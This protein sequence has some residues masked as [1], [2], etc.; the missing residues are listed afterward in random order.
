MFGHHPFVWTPLRAESIITFKTEGDGE[1][2]RSMPNS[3]T[4]NW[5][6]DT[7]ADN[8]WVDD[9]CEASF[10]LAKMD[11]DT[12][13]IIYPRESN[14]NTGEWWKTVNNEGGADSMVVSGHWAGEPY[15]D[16]YTRVMK[17][18]GNWSGG[19]DGFEANYQGEVS[20]E[21]IPTLTT[22]A[23]PALG[24][25]K[26]AWIASLDEIPTE[27][28]EPE[29]EPCAYSNWSEWG[30]CTQVMST[31]DGSED[32]KRTRTRTK[33]SGGA[34]CND[35]LEEEEMC[36]S[37]Q[38]CEW[39]DWSAWSEWTECDWNNAD[40][41]LTQTRTRQK[42]LISP[43]SGGQAED[44]CPEGCQ[45][46]DCTSWSGVPI[47]ETQSR[48]CPESANDCPYGTKS[49]T[50]VST[51]SDGTRVTKY[52]CISCSQEL[53]DDPNAVNTSGCPTCKSGYAQSPSN[54]T[55]NPCV[56]TEEVCIDPLALNHQPEQFPKV[57][58]KE[59]W[60]FTGDC[61]NYGCDDPNRELKPHPHPQIGNQHDICG[62]TC[63]KGYEFDE[64]NLC[65]KKKS[66][67]ITTQS[68]TVS[69]VIQEEEESNTGIILGLLGLTAVGAWYFTQKN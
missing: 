1:E 33:T 36:H 66:A 69:T 17:I 54:I 10:F 12:I 22:I 68:S 63:K 40:I 28:A 57:P 35:P 11:N 21:A 8:G 41:G 20:V 7:H 53:A 47:I 48:P 43:H 38:E 59:V 16:A 5:N 9:R 42:T 23:R 27:C 44:L 64:N 3:P 31:L 56:E 18:V 52:K 2:W 67:K 62:D 50:R 4:E 46:D 60:E 34:N 32:G 65:V 14:Y 61:C 58:C 19:D 6:D 25:A 45:D 26:W 29:T 55:P 24:N 30:E 15:I 49:Q 37:P 51:E 13:G 39:S